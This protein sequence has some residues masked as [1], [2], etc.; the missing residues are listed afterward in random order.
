MP[1]ILAWFAVVFAFPDLHVNWTDAKGL[2][3]VAGGSEE[4]LDRCIEGGIE[5][6]YRFLLRHCRRRVGWFDACEGNKMEVHALRRDPVSENYIV[7]VDRHSDE[8]SPAKNTFNE[9]ADARAALGTIDF[10]PLEFI[11][12]GPPRA[13]NKGYYVGVRVVA[14]CKRDF[15]DVVLDLPYLLTFGLMKT[16]RYDSGWIAFELDGAK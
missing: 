13:E 1:A 11:A 3:V 6:R 12:G 4:L 10:I 16:N 15:S 7:T 8:K 14:D 9:L 5:V 2:R